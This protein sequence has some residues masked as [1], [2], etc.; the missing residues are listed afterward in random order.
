MKK[1]IL[2][3]V[4]CLMPF[5]LMGQSTNVRFEVEGT[6][7]KMNRGEDTL[8]PYVPYINRSNISI[9]TESG[10]IR[11]YQDG[12]ELKVVAY[13]PLYETN[14]YV[15]TGGDDTKSGLTDGDAWAH[16]PWMSTWT[17]STVLVA[18][19]VVNMNKGNTWTIATPGAAYMT[20]AQSGSAGKPI[21][22]TSYGTGA[23]PII[24]ISTDTDFPV[25]YADGKSYI[26]FDN[27]EI[28][29]FTTVHDAQH[30]QSGFRIDD[31]AATPHDWIITNCTIHNIGYVGIY[32]ADDAYNITIGDVN[33][34]TTATTTNY[35]NHIYDCSYA[36]I[37]LEGGNV[38][39]GRSDFKI[40]YNYIHNL[41]L[42]TD[43]Y[44]IALSATVDSD[45]WPAYST[46]R[47]NRVEDV[48]WWHGI[49]CHGAKYVYIQD[50]YIRNCRMGIVA[51]GA[52]RV[53]HPAI[54][55]DHVWIE[56]NTIVQPGASAVAY[57]KAIEVNSES[58]A[59]RATD[60]YITDNNIYWEVR[61]AESAAH[62]IQVFVVDGITIEGN[63]IYSGPTG[64]TNG[65]IQ[66]QAT[67]GQL[68][69][70]VT[71][72]NNFISQWDGG[73]DIYVADIDG[74]VAIHSNI[75]HNA[76]DGIW[77]AS[78]VLDAGTMTIYNNTIMSD[79][80]VS[81]RYPIRFSS[82]HNL[83]AG[84]TV[85]IRDN[86][87]AYSTNGA[88]LYIQGPNT[89]GGTLTIDYNLYWNC[90]TASPYR[91]TGAA[92]AWA[93]WQGLGYDVNGFNNTS[94]LFTNGG[95][96]YLLDT[97][98]ALGT[99]SPAINAGTNTG[100]TTDYFGNAR[101]GNYDIGAIEKQ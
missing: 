7:V 31:D 94:P 66:L 52:D 80:N 24:N 68:C 55:I 99:G 45:I 32:F 84:G 91:V 65:A 76:G 22:T 83:A 17:G 34:T 35:S 12:V 97:D 15:K 88:G 86:I 73:M 63:K 100:V 39:T 47:Y 40:Y 71:I 28:N 37:G 46:I 51:F 69:K 79:I 10:F 38:A 60:I 67:G 9:T 36:G 62:G 58:V 49:D 19:D 93:A 18:G 23:Q 64:T 33:A 59:T 43:T 89:L 95:G 30:Q 3:I 53:D 44:G 81:S 21:T 4:L 16:H 20:V 11:F 41:G 50:N 85:I 82:T 56:R 77:L 87:L 5:A 29:H 27:L 61:E 1:I 8:N 6:D 98:F 101:V 42:A 14:Y 26:T 78:E 92:Y 70:N 54:T 25:I 2:F 75:I 13:A 48:T 74:D 90:S 96:S 57:T 72:K